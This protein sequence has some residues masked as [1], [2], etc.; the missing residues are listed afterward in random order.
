VKNSTAN[1]LTLVGSSGIRFSRAAAVA[2]CLVLIVLFEFSC[3]LNIDSRYLTKYFS[4]VQRLPIASNSSITKFCTRHGF[5]E[6][7]FSGKH[8]LRWE[9]E[10]NMLKL[11][12]S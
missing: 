12:G 9:N 1:K 4:F 8:V 11:T 7:A 6:H 3:L 10:I 2:H 5:V